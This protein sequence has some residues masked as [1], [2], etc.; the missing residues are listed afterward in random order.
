MQQILIAGEARAREGACK[1][2]DAITEPVAVTAVRSEAF[3]PANFALAVSIV[4]TVVAGLLVTCESISLSLGLSPEV[5]GGGGGCVSGSR[6][7]DQGGALV[8]AG[9][10][11]LGGASVD[12]PIPAIPGYGAS[13]CRCSGFPSG[14]HI[15]AWLI[16]S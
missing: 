10:V 15:W 3:R 9:A 2:H 12:V 6:V 14:A 16:N 13:R 5:R 8:Q 4:Q 11:R 7:F 1:P